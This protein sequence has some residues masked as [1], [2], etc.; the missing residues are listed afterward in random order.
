MSLLYIIK[1]YCT[2]LIFLK[3]VQTSV[4]T[5]VLSTYF[6]KR[7]QFVSV[8]NIDH[9]CHIQDILPLLHSTAFVPPHSDADLSVLFTVTFLHQ[10]IFGKNHNTPRSVTLRFWHY[11]LEKVKV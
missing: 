11:S 6:F 1:P 4:S 9:F 10:F 8:Y 3:Q 2:T 5:E 7:H